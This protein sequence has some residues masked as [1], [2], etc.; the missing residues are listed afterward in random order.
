M[1]TITAKHVTTSHPWSTSRTSTPV[2][3]KLRQ[4]YQLLSFLLGNERL[5]AYLLCGLMALFYYEEEE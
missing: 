4:T 5:L 2:P 3:C 1:H